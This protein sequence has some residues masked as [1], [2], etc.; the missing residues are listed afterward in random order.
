MSDPRSEP[1]PNSDRKSGTS[2]SKE[3]GK[4]SPHDNFLSPIVMLLSILGL[5]Y[6]N[7]KTETCPD[8]PKSILTKVEDIARNLSDWFCY[9]KGWKAASADDSQIDRVDAEFLGK[10]LV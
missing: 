2:S 5:A 1:D 6:K 4:L 8:Q 9:V 3:T 7:L 10:L